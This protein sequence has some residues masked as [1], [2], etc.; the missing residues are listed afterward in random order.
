MEE[1]VT[2]GAE[3]T[4]DSIIGGHQAPGVAIS[5]G[6][7]KWLEMN[8]SQC[9]IGDLLIDEEPASFLV[10]CDKV[11]DAGADSSCLDGVDICSGQL[12]SE[13]G[14]FTIGFEI[15]AAEGCARDTDCDSV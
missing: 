9:S 12:T 2:S 15:A 14:V 13:K 10:V 7:L 8:L 3:I 1:K 5:N 11:L 6:N 4:I